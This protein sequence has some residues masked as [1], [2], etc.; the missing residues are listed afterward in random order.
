MKI[1]QRRA[2]VP[3]SLVCAVVIA[4]EGFAA[5]QQPTQAQANAI[6]QSCRSDYMKHCSSVPTGG[7][8]ALACLRENASVV[9]SGCQ[10]ALRAASGGATTPK[11]DAKPPAPVQGSQ[12]SQGSSSAS[13][14]HT[15]VNDRGSAVVYQPQVISWPDRHILN[16]RM[17]LALS[18]A[19]AKAPTLGTI[20]VAFT[21]FS[22][23]ASRTVTLTEPKLTS[24]KFPPRPPSRRSGSSR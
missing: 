15:I 9:S 13:W 21:T 6:R 7:A 22:D 4:F 2:L 24:V 5:A 10:Q 12:S 17:A 1:P 19:G 14:P 8:A 3:A 16:T 18:P 23:L 11:P 20:E